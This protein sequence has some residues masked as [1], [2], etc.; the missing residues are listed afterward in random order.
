MNT[1]G[2]LLDLFNGVYLEK[3]QRKNKPKDNFIPGDDNYPD[4]SIHRYE[5]YYTDMS[6]SDDESSISGSDSSLSYDYRNNG[7]QKKIVKPSSLFTTISGSKYFTPKK[8]YLTKSS[9]NLKKN[10]MTA[11]ILRTKLENKEQIVE[12]LNKLSKKNTFIDV[13]Y[14]MDEPLKLL[15]PTFKEFRGVLVYFKTNKNL[16]LYSIDTTKSQNNLVKLSGEE[17]VIRT[18]PKKIETI[19]L[20]TSSLTIDTIEI[21]EP[22]DMSVDN[23]NKLLV[24]INNKLS[25]I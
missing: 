21:I 3:K 5:N 4:D 17:A 9:S 10:F 8:M 2:I 15:I 14:K 6:Y 13:L 7:L 16:T 24:K 22:K 23:I 25:N 12:Y 11:T 18:L 19:Y 20:P 1:N